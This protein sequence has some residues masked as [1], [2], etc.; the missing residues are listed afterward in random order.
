MEN[1]SPVLENWS[2][3][4]KRAANRMK[5]NGRV[6]ALGNWPSQLACARLRRI[7]PMDV[8]LKLKMEITK[9]KNNCYIFKTAN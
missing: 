4:V 5:I 9:E 7:R 8:F 6:R 1:G 3:G 2:G